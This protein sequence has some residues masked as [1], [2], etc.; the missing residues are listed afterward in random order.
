MPVDRFT[1]A[2]RPIGAGAKCFL[3]AEVAQTHDGSLGLAHSFVDAIA[4][5]GADAVKFQ[6]HVAAAESTPAEPFRVEFSY[7]DATRYDY[8]K[9]MEFTAEQWGGLKAHAEDRGL[10]FL[11]S[12]FSLAAVELLRGLG[13][14][15]WKVASGEISNPPLLDAM[16]AT[17]KPILLS[18][19]LSGWDEIAAAVARFDT[20]GLAFAVL[21]CTSRYPTPL[22]AVGLNVM[23]QMR[24]FGGPVGLSDHSGTIYPALAAMARGAAIVEVHATFHKAMFGPDVP[25]SLTLDQIRTLA[26][27][28]DAIHDMDA[29]PVDKD[30]A[31]AELAHVRALFNKSVALVA[32]KARGTVLDAAMLT[33][34]KPADGIPARELGACVGRRL[35]RD[36]PA[37]R[38][39]AWDDLEP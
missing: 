14:G 20:A 23:D 21:Q 32:P 6:T 29:H 12:P 33:T 5:A 3:V 11:S 30:A 2:G 16:I 17:G 19:G 10:V 35:A 24:R 8:W 9:R 34:K 18:T 37:D 13:I 38:V 25:A 22:A 28:R 36:V 1:V 26:E 39:L 31:D 15:A 4:L 27:A 7:A